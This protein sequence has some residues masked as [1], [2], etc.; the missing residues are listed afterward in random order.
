LNAPVMTRIA[1]GDISSFVLQGL[2]LVLRLHIKEPTTW[3]VSMSPCLHASTHTAHLG[4]V[5]VVLSPYL[6]SRVLHRR[7]LIRLW[8]RHRCTWSRLTWHLRRTILTRV[9]VGPRDERTGD[10][11]T[12]WSSPLFMLRVEQRSTIAHYSVASPFVPIMMD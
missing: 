7:C 3:L 9:F 12:S 10:A 2:N 11:S 1:L 8:S 4:S 6:I 5:F